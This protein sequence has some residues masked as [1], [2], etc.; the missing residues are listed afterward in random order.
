MIACCSR[1]R[2]IGKKGHIPWYLPADLS[3]FKKK[4]MGSTLVMGRLTWESFSGR[5]LP[6][7]GMIV[8]SSHEIDCPTSVSVCPSPEMAVS[9]APAD[10]PIFLIGGARLYEWGIHYASDLFLTEIHAHYD[11]DVYFPQLLPHWEELSC[12]DVKNSDFEH[13]FSFMHYQNCSPTPLS[14]ST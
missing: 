6:G 8:I 13:P 2:V 4:T 11:G 5:V 9:K 7:R 3:F 10:R 12:Q 14:C 1:N